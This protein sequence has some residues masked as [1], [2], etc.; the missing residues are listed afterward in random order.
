M[1]PQI[2][3]DALRKSF[4]NFETFYLI[5]LDECHHATGN[6]PYAKI[7]KVNLS[8]LFPSMPYFFDSFML[9]LLGNFL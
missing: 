6:H 5:V 2:L 3:L 9:T 7:M 1:T 8:D 4:L